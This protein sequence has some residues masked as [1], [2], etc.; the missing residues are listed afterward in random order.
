MAN[1][2]I[3]GRWRK[4]PSES[5]RYEV[6]WTNWLLPGEFL[7]QAYVMINENTLVVPL[8]ITDPFFLDTPTGATGPR[9]CVFF[10]RGG[11]N[12]T[13]YQVTHQIYTSSGQFAEREILYDIEEV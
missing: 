12:L 2:P 9:G 3:I 5:L 7:V 1:N 8:E 10:I 4:Q 6:D 11:K 13:Q